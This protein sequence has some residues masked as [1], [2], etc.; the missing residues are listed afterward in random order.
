MLMKKSFVVFTLD[1]DTRLEYTYREW[2]STL[3]QVQFKFIRNLPLMDTIYT[4]HLP[5]TLKSSMTFYIR[6]ILILMEDFPPAN[7]DCFHP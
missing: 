6:N 2:V 1:E 7:G 3:D 4:L 5:N